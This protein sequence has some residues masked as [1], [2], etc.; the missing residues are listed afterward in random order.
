MV[1]IHI[2]VTIYNVDLADNLANKMGLGFNDC[3][4]KSSSL[5]EGLI[6]SYPRFYQVKKFHQQNRQLEPNRPGSVSRKMIV[7]RRTVH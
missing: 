7:N 5:E 6:A 1:D 2:L 4:I 3:V